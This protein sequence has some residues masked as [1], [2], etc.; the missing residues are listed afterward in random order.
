VRSAHPVDAAAAL[1]GD[2]LARLQTYASHE[3]PTGD[4]DA[5]D[6][7]ADVLEA[8]YRELGARTE[9]IS[10]DTGDHLVARWG[11]ATAPHVLLL[12]HHDTVWPRGT[13]TS[14][15]LAGDGGVL[16]GPGVYDMKGGLVVAETAVAV[17]HRCGMEPARPV[18]LVVVAD[19]EV[20]SPTGRAVV[21]AEA[22]GAVAALGLE[23][24]HPDGRLKSARLGSTRVRLEVTGRAAHAGLDPEA[25]VSAVD[26][27]VDQLLAVR[28]VVAGEPGVLCNVGTIAGG[29]RTNVVPA[30]A[31][32]EIGLRFVDGR[33]E[34][35]VLGALRGLAAVREGA[36]V[37]VHTLSSRPAW[38]AVDDGLLARVTAAGRAVGQ[39]VAA[40][41]ARGAADTNVTGAAGVPSLDGFGPLGAG[42]HASHE[43]I[44]IASLAER[45]A[46]LASVLATL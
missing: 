35:R 46:L 8:R 5:L 23:P 2:A 14:M 29:G 11:D 28:E 17:L 42:A 10:Q 9:R 20:G 44:V 33:A 43:Q 38:Q 40:A 30:E 22:D 1:A 13:L 21:T 45:A 6:A 16:H 32:A 3:T 24:P 12:G 39:E 4:A 7:L 34:G 27:L 18:R 25:G 31:T 19:E 37:V 36:E 26:E 41:P 15:P